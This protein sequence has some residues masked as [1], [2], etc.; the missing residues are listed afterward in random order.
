MAGQARR[1]QLIATFRGGRIPE[2]EVRTDQPWAQRLQGFLDH[3]A[4]RRIA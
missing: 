1:D 4:R 3:A 2:L